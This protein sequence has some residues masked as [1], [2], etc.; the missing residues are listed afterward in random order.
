[1]CDAQGQALWIP[2]YWMHQLETLPPRPPA[3]DGSSLLCNQTPSALPTG[4]TAAAAEQ[5]GGGGSLSVSFWMESPSHAALVALQR[6][7]LPHGFDNTTWGYDAV[8]LFIDHMPV[9]GQPASVS[10][11]ASSA[12][13]GL[14]LA[15]VDSCCSAHPRPGRARGRRGGCW[16]PAACCVSSAPRCSRRCRCHSSRTHCTPATL[17]GGH[18]AAAAAA[19][20]AA[21][22]LELAATKQPLSHTQTLEAWAAWTAVMTAAAAP[23]RGRTLSGP[24]SRRRRRR[25]GSLWR[26]S[27]RCWPS[28]GQQRRQPEGGESALRRRRRRWRRG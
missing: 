12:A 5:R 2:A 7:A 28:C 11:V 3:A 25:C 21:L 1:M 17:P 23:P 4:E 13:S 22:E 24:P 15:S 8:R 6:R 10:G 20:A 27:R 26:A 19:A 18:P 9:R 16:R 14:P